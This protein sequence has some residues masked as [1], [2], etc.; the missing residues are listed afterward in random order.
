MI[1]YSDNYSDTSGKSWQFKRD[2]VPANNGDFTINN[3][4][5]FKCKEAP[6]GKTVNHNDGK[7]SVKDAKMV[8][9]L[10]YLSNFWRSLE[11]PLINCKVHLELNWNEDYNLSSA[12]DSAKFEIT[13]AKLHVSKVTLSTKDSVNLIKQLSIGF[14]RSAC[15]NNHQTKPEKVIEK[16]KN[17]YK[18]LNVSFQGVRR[19][20]VLAHV[21]FAGAANDEAGIKD[22]KNHFLPRGEIKNYDALIDGRDFYDQPINYLIKQYDEVRKVSTGHRDDYTAGSLL[23]YAY[24]KDNY[25]LI[26]IDLSKEKALDVD[27]RAI[28]QI[29]FQGVVGGDNNT[30]IRLHTI[31]EQSKETMLEFSKG[32]AKVLQLHVNG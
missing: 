2:E 23:D 20:F 21:V 8:V 10:K 5:S 9:P 29:V 28:Q 19:L 3:F 32:T 22:N 16:G 26:A 14:K 18:L 15:W 30:K 17:L 12:G 6:L 31:L 1:E 11:M 13:G 7:N 4:Q 25:R 24:F 27:P